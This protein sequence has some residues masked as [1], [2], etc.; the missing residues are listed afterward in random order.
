MLLYDNAFSPFARKVRL[1]L[2]AKGLV[3]ESVDALANDER[4]R[5][6]SVN[7]RVEVPVLVDGELTVGG[8]ADI[9]AYLDDRYPEPPLLPAEPGARV[10]AREWQRL[11]DSVFDA[12]VHDVSLWMWPMLRRTDQ[13]PAG[14]REAAAA[15]LGK[16]YARLDHAIGPGPFVCGAAVS[17]ADLAL[18]PHVSAAKAV[19]LPFEAAAHPNL[20]RWSK[21]LRELPF[22]REENVALQASVGRLMANPQRYESTKIVWRGDRLEWLFEKGYVDFWVRELREGRVLIPSSL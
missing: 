22:V 19:G 11:A 1:A 5:L 15:D 3:F 7:T 21:A 4:A 20:A 10:K 6:A 14:L 18:L 16:L 12:I 17:I 2:R 8:S 13:P 9:L